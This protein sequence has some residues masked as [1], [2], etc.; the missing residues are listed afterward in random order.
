M[1]QLDDPHNPDRLLLVFPLERPV[2][3]HSDRQRPMSEQD[4]A[5]QCS[6]LDELDARQDEVLDQ[7]DDLN[8]RIELLLSNYNATR[9]QELAEDQESVPVEQAGE[10]QLPKAA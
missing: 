10:Q 8:N 2:P 4:Q 1:L 6:L 7:L 9:A 5:R 3:T